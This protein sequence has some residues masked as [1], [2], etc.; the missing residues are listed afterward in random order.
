MR[1]TLSQSAGL[2]TC[3]PP[4][5]SPPESST[6]EAL[7]TFSRTTCESTVNATSLL[8]SEAG[9]SPCKLQAGRQTDLFGREV[10]PASRS[11]APEKAEEKTTPA[12][13]GQSSDASLRSATLQQ[14]LANRLHQRMDVDGSPEFVLTWKEWAME[15]GLPICALRGRLRPISVSGCSG[16]PSPQ[17]HDVTTRGN[18]EA[19]YHHFPHDLSNAALLVPWPT[20]NVPNRSCEMDKSGRDGRASEETMAKNSRPLQEQVVYGLTSASSSAETS[21]SEPAQTPS[22][23]SALNPAH[24]RWLQGYPEAWDRAV[25]GQSEW[26]SWQQK[27][28]ASEGCAD[29][30]TR[31]FPK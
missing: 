22:V 10:A 27:L 15:S 20:P 2:A 12:T 11:R 28:T 13:S 21:T 9:H 8:A 16:W 17:A 7:P 19:D 6:P 4:I 30:E 1:S 23:G 26:D 18:T 29:T 31:L 14:S 3:L 24:S 25:P 5:S